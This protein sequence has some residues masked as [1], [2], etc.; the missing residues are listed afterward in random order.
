MPIVETPL[1]QIFVSLSATTRAIRDI[2]D[3]GKNMPHKSSLGSGAEHMSSQRLGARTGHPRAAF[4]LVE[5]LV[6]IGIIAVLIG[7]LLPALARAKAAANTVACSSNLRQVYLAA[8]NYATEYKDS[9][10]FG[11]AFNKMSPVNGRPAG[12]DTSYITWF[13]SCDKYMTAKAVEQIPLDANTGYYDG[14]TR[15]RF[16]AAFKC[17]AIDQ[18]TFRQSIH[19]GYHS[20]AMVNMTL[21]LNANTSPANPPPFMPAKFTQLYPDNALFWDAPL[22]SAAESVTP[23]MF[24][25]ARDT[26]TGYTYPA[27]HMDADQLC[28]PKSPE[29]RYRGPGR[30]RFS[31]SADPMKNPEGPIAWW[32]DRFVQNHPQLKPFATSMN[33][34]FGGGTVI[35]FTINGPRFRH[36]NKDICVVVFA[37]GSVRPLRLYTGRIVKND[38]YDTEF[39]RKFI[40][41]KWPS[42]KQDSGTVPTG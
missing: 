21:E 37:D 23:A 10:P 27:C 5:L 41:L 11:M 24:W 36:G 3:R 38:Y 35:T 31:A 34:D 25:V 8:R 13:S 18:G 30:D 12:S 1:G 28:Q 29:L 4:T 2:T 16:S 32:S 19:Y 17:P 40:M 15:R 20:A 33:S 6:V 26:A 39:R 14:A 42:N 9:L 7:V 22:Y